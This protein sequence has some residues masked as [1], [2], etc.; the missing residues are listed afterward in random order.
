MGYSRSVYDA[1]YATL[2]ARRMQAEQEADRRR[3]QFYRMEPRGQEIDRLLTHTG[4]EAAK[5]VLGGKDV[6]QALEALRVENQR[7]QQERAA[8]LAKHGMRPEDLEPAYTCPKCKDRGNVDGRMCDCMKELLRAQA[9]RQLNTDTPLEQCTF[10]TFD[11]SY[12]AD[13]PDAQGRIPRKWME[14][15]F[16][17]CQRYAYQFNGRSESLL[18]AGKTGLGKTHLS[19]AIAKVVIDRG[20]GVVYGSVQNLLS[21]LAYEHFGRSDGNTMQSL[22]DCDLL[23]LDD[24][25]TEFR[26]QFSI[27]AL[28]NIVNSRQLAQ[29]P[30]IMSTNLTIREMAEYYTERFSS[31]V[32]GGYKRVQFIGTDVRQQKRLGH[33]PVRPATTPA[34]HRPPQH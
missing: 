23:I 21:R 24:L 9:R 31:R 27:A 7:L 5:A 22:L 19:L 2:N 1:V 30:V 10:E 29:K 34:G 17:F 20:F 13:T 14:R 11:L 32:I 3:A 15:Q 33:G 4:V 12:Y 6:R 25:G 26:S 28:Y 8:L 18:M 16:S